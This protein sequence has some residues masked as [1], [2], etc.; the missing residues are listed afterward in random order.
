MAY[1]PDQRLPLSVPIA[2]EEDDK[3]TAYELQML[4]TGAYYDAQM[5]IA[6]SEG[7]EVLSSLVSDSRLHEILHNPYDEGIDEG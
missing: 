6:E 3:M 7:L 1:R 4:E 2:D 5:A